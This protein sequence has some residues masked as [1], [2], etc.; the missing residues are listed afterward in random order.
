MDIALDNYKFSKRMQIKIIKI[1]SEFLSDITPYEN[2]NKIIIVRETI[3][4]F[5]KNNYNDN[6]ALFRRNYCILKKYAFII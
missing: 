6:K 4:N 3:L 1:I 2:K 5:C